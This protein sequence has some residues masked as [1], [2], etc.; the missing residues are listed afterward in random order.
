MVFLT[1]TTFF[2][3]EIEHVWN[4]EKDEKIPLAES[5]SFSQTIPGTPIQVDIFS[6]PTA[7]FANEYEETPSISDYHEGS[8]T[9]NTCVRKLNVSFM[10]A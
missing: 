4:F 8:Y 10:L 9:S 6:S 1:K 3:L 2:P 5:V 7:A